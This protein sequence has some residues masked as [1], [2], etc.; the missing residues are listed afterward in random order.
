[1]EQ[2]E[3]KFKLKNPKLEQSFSQ[4]SFILIKNYV[5]F[6]SKRSDII[7]YSVKLRFIQV[8]LNSLNTLL[9]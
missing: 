6:S 7:H 4:L 1:M 3:L 9:V 5:E 2:S 8:A